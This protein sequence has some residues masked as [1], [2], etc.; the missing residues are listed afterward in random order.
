MSDYVSIY[1]TT[2]APWGEV[3]ADEFIGSLETWAWEDRKASAPWLK[4]RRD[5]ILTDRA[6]DPKARGWRVEFRAV[7]DEEE[8]A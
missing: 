3:F 6:L 1:A 4:V 2:T 7:A 8:V 5:I